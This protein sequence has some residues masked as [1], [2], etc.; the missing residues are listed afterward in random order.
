LVNQESSFNSAI[1]RQAAGP[2]NFSAIDQGFAGGAGI[3]G[4]TNLANVL[5][6]GT[7]NRST[8]FQ[9]FDDVGGEN[10]ALVRQ[11]GDGNISLIDQEG[12]MNIATVNQLDGSNS[13]VNQTGTGNSATVTQGTP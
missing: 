5:Q 6:D 1:V 8:I 2:D 3:G 4:D 7:G 10:R 9:N 11:I 12:L 13:T